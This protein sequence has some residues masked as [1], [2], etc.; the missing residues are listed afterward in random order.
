MQLVEIQLLIMMRHLELENLIILRGEGMKRKTVKIISLI[1]ITLLTTNTY[2]DLKI[3]EYFNGLEPQKHINKI[4]TDERKNELKQNVIKYD[5]IEDL[6][7]LYNTDV[8]NLWNNWEN[9]KS[10]QDIH[11]D[12]LDSAANVEDAA[13]SADSEFMEGMYRAQG[14]AMRIQADQNADDSYSN[15]LKNYLEEKSI[16]KNTKE[17][18]IDFKKSEFELYSAAGAIKEAE[19]NE[20][21][22]KNAYENGAGTK[23][24]YLTSEKATFDA[25]SNFI[26]SESTC[27]TNKRNLLI[28]CG[29]K[30]DSDVVI[31][32]V[33]LNDN[34]DVTKINF[35]NDYNNALKNS[36]QLVIYKRNFE[37]AE[38]DEVKN[39]H[40]INI[41]NAPNAIWNDLDSKYHN[42]IDA[43]TSL[44]NKKVSLN[45][46][47]DS[48]N[49]A[50]NSFSEGAISKKELSSAE[51]AYIVAKCS[52][53]ETKYDIKKAILEYEFSR[54]GYYKF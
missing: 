23:L 28:N 39:I 37:N 11:E 40:E 49:E 3:T 29:K 48:Y 5:D 42:I 22:A 41:N 26:L 31:S 47:L 4:Y 35:E 36:I 16:V 51:Y 2:A 27:T 30:I 6:I 32:D 8:A 43:I 34:L 25:K 10:A 7:H 52:L 18:F 9:N 21:K 33:D 50:K 38:T 1:L 46:A 13:A 45:V 53:E 54:D 15:F 14:L 12:Y 19:R 44:D 24:E 20:E 17:L